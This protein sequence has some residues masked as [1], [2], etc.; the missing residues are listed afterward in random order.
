MCSAGPARQSSSGCG[1]GY[2][3]TPSLTTVV[4][5]HVAG[6]RR[7]AR[8]W[9]GGAWC[10]A[11]ACSAGGGCMIGGA[12]GRVVAVRL[13]AWWRWCCVGVA[14]RA[15]GCAAGCVAGC[16][17]GC[18]GAYRVV[19]R[20][21]CDAPRRPPYPCAPRARSRVTAAS[22]PFS[23]ARP[24]GVLPSC[25]RRGGVGGEREGAGP[26]AWLGSAPVPPPPPPHARCSSHGCL[27]RNLAAR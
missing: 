16:A 20:V 26:R 13:G 9:C 2:H 7:G 19:P 3:T 27:R 24:S 12:A 15:A 22:Y 23:D 4:V 6:V 21:S 25:T 11:G 1:T 5:G 10:A 14:G 8:W 18:R 17:A